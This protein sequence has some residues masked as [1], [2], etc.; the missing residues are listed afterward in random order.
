MLATR[1]KFQPT[2]EQQAASEAKRERL[3]SIADQIGKMT[4][5]QRFELAMQY[6]ITMVTGHPVSPFNACM[7]A[8]Q[9]PTA[10]VV[11]GFNQWHAH[12]R[13]V[14]KGAKAIGMYAPKKIGSSEAETP[15]TDTA[16]QEPGT[17]A[18]SSTRFVIVNVF[19]IS[20]TE[21]M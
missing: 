21:V 19:D 9:M 11:G 12:G 10:T 18:K 3:H 8:T 16:G 6:P 17:P 13:K 2:P 7:I 20:Q 5:E 14:V 1:K 4:P 15:A